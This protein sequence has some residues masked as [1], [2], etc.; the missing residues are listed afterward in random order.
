MEAAV[1]MKHHHPQGSPL[2]AMEQI[3]SV[4]RELAPGLVELASIED[5]EWC[6]SIL[7]PL[8]FFEREIVENVKVVGGIRR[9]AIPGELVRI[10][11]NINGLPS[12]TDIL[13][14]ILRAEMLPLSK[15]L[16]HLIDDCPE[17]LVI[18]RGDQRHMRG[19]HKFRS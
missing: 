10:D 18:R 2:A 17:G 15:G 12:V 5:D 4:M 19:D 1:I 7:F 11:F 9:V 14:D 13:R 8:G 6:R 3:V 16:G